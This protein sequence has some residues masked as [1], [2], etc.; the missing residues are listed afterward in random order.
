VP[1]VW[2]TGTDDQVI[3]TPGNPRMNNVVIESGS[4]NFVSDDAWDGI[5]D[6]RRE[7]LG[8]T[9]QDPTQENE[10]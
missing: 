4:S 7:N 9:D 8:L 10:E 2:N 5:D 3:Q 1:R 6:D